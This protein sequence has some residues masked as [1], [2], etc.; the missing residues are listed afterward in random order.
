MFSVKH[1]KFSNDKRYDQVENNIRN[2]VELISYTGLFNNFLNDIYLI[3][4]ALSI[5]CWNTSLYPNRF[6]SLLSV[7]ESPNDFYGKSRERR[8]IR[9]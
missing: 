7:I 3:E 5:F 9:D 4:Y 2:T 1:K 8:R 6:D